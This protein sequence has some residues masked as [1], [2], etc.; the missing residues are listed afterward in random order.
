MSFQRSEDSIDNVRQ[1]LLGKDTQTTN[2]WSN[3]WWRNSLS[4]V[5][6]VSLNTTFAIY[7]MKHHCVMSQGGWGSWRSS[8]AEK[9][10]W[11]L[12]A[13]NLF[14]ACVHHRVHWVPKPCMCWFYWLRMAKPIRGMP[15]T[16][17][18]KWFRLIKTQVISL[19]GCFSQS[20]WQVQG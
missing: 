13:V 20:F 16:A 17:Q 15:C 10:T 18:I 4:R 6:L 3:H 2:H 14:Q 12:M 19:F 11:F 5:C 9:A 1:Y 7:S 8:D